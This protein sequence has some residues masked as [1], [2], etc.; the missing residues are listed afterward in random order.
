MPHIQ[1]CFMMIGF[2]MCQLHKVCSS[3][4]QFTMRQCHLI[5]IFLFLSSLL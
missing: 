3:P 2:K 1:W 5:I 4:A